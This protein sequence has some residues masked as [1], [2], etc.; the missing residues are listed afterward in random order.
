[1]DI[2]RE[3]IV[4]EPIDENDEHTFNSLFLPLSP[5]NEAPVRGYPSNNFDS[6]RVRVSALPS[7][8]CLSSD[9]VSLIDF[10]HAAHV[11]HCSPH[12]Q[13]SDASIGNLDGHCPKG[14]SAPEAG[15]KRAR[16]RDIRRRMLSRHSALISYICFAQ[17]AVTSQ[18]HA[19]P[20]ISLVWAAA[21]TN[22]HAVC[23]P[24]NRAQGRKGTRKSK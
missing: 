24:S 6:I 19:S 13:H 17:L 5:S 18:H 14:Y 11:L 3:N 23:T 12:I 10:G 21:S 8:R 15:K 2:K 4:L 22:L 9:Q 1:L 7:A 20:L 16:T